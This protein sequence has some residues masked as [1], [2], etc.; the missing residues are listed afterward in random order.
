MSTTMIPLTTRVEPELRAAV[1][2]YRRQQPE[3][4]PLGAVRY[5]LKL[6]LK[7]AQSAQRRELQ[8]TTTTS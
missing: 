1:H 7:A 2:D 5:L 6:G 4:P 8:K 3:I